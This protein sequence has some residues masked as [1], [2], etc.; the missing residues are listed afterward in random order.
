MKSEDL[1]FLHKFIH[2]IKES[3]PM[4]EAALKGGLERAEEI[5]DKE[6]HQN[7]GD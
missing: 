5:I 4:K 7:E 2:M 1:K 6:Y 3:N